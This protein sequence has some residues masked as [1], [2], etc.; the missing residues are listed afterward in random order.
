MASRIQ[1]LVALTT[2][3]FICSLSFANESIIV[4]S[5][6]STQ[7]SGLFG[8]ILPKFKEKTGID[9]KVIAQGTGQALETGRRG[10][11]D[12]LFVHNRKAEDQFVADGFGV[13][14]KDVMYND[15]VLI[16]P[17]DDPAGLKE[18][19]NIKDA[20][21]RLAKNNALFISRG[22]NSGTHAA[23]LRYWDSIK[24]NPK[25]I[26]GYRESGSGM[27]ATLN[28]TAGLNGYTLSDRG[29]WLS[30]KN[31]QDLV[32]VFAD[33]PPMFNP[34]GIILVNPKRHPHVKHIAGEAFI[35]WITSQEGRDAIA[36]YTING[37]QLFFPSPSDHVAHK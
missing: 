2:T 36:E 18:S 35:D 13:N 31:R 26:Q 37:E 27:G 24:T 12:V 3:L 32:V 34:Y 20:M 8:H 30:F 4:A 14:R 7:N 1:R 22:D 33:D 17:K 28:L 10:D 23:E 5:T 19:T 21:L 15:F 6:T 16:G 29:T 25:S 9:V 11:A